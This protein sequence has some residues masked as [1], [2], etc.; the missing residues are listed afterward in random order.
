M[1]WVVRFANRPV[2]ILGQ[3]PVVDRDSGSRRPRDSRRD[4]GGSEARLASF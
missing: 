1:I 2:F 3:N 4:G